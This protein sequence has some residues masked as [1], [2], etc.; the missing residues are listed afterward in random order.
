MSEAFTIRTRKFM[1]N[2]LLKRKQM[3]LD[4]F[5]PNRA[6]VPR[7]EL[8]EALA[9]SYKVPNP[10]TIVLFGFKTAFGG[11]KSTGFALVYDSV[12]DRKLVEPRYRYVRDG[13]LQKIERSRKQ[14][15]ELK[16]RKKKVRGKK[17]ADVGA[18]PKK[19]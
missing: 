1:T 15:K 6:N 19:K 2:R 16:N 10:Q 3:V 12:E 13:L 8:A 11:G 18:A 5:H 14:M 17:K 9:K 4:V 7:A